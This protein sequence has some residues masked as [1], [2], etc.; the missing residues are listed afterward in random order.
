MCFQYYLNSFICLNF[1]VIGKVLEQIK[2]STKLIQFPPPL[3]DCSC[4]GKFI[5][6]YLT[7]QNLT[8][9]CSLK[10]LSEETVLLHNI[11][12]GLAIDYFSEDLA[13]KPII[14]KIICFT[15]HPF[16]FTIFEFGIEISLLFLQP[17]IHKSKLVR[18]LPAKLVNFYIVKFCW[19]WLA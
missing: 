1:I 3:Q 5:S 13:C 14:Y 10:S 18:T 9:H 6:R 12:K 15:L 2:V 11:W 7:S 8:F 4:G 16:S 19:L 17:Q